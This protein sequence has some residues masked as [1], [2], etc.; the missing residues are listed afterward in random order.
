MFRFARFSMRAFAL[1]AAM[2]LPAAAD[3]QCTFS[4]SSTPARSVLVY[5]FAV[6]EV[7][8]SAVLGVTLTFTGSTS[9]ID[10]IVVPAQ[11][12]GQRLHAIR[13]LHPRDADVRIDSIAGRGALV[14]RHTAAAPVDISYD[15]VKDWT[16]PLDHPYEFH[17]MIFSDYVEV[18]GANALVHPR[19]DRYEPV[20]AHFD[21]TALPPSWTLATSFGTVEVGV[22]ASADRCQTVIGT[23]SDIGDALYAAGEFRVRRFDIR[24]KPAVLAIRGTW[25]FSDSAVV[26]EIQRDVGAVRAFWHDDN[27]PYLLVTWAPFDRDYGSD[28]GSAFTNALWIFMS[29]KESLASQV[30]Q[31][32]HESFHTWDPGRMGAQV[33]S[34]ESKLGWFREGFTMY[35]ADMIAHRAR[36]ISLATAVERANR[37]LRSFA[38]STDPYTRGDVIARWLDG[39]IRA[40][41]HNTRSLDDVMRA[42]VQSANQPLTLERVLA[43]ADRN[44]APSDRKTLR[45]LLAAPGPVPANFSA[46]VLAPC[47]RVSLDSMYAFDAGFDVQASI[48]ASR[49]TGVR[50]GSAAY[51]AGMRD[52][53][54]LAGASIYPGNPDK[55]AVFTVVNDSTKSRI[56]YLPRGPVFAAPQLHVVDDSGAAQ[57]VRC[58]R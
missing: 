56:S 24:D 52:G 20:I 47:V 51:A 13:N 32:T 38:G 42:L 23:W 48:A 57:P 25:P 53:Q 5:R 6:R 18:T 54:R 21:W 29:R 22:G 58:G 28:D 35:Y 3:A 4:N 10:T 34:E 36:L 33:D 40:H 30:T 7:G 14:V 27:F 44:L 16:G 15:V 45:D 26:A 8:D 46:G 19:A 1:C 41:T 49:A 2:L 50:E 39:A 55:P 11:W 43:T 31:L 9:G 12:A 17:P 37:H